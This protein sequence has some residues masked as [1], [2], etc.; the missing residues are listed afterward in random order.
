MFLG[1]EGFKGRHELK[2]LISYG[3]YLAIS[4]R[5]G[6]LLE[7]D[8]HSGDDGY[9]IRSLYL[10]DNGDSAYYDKLNGI[11]DRKKYRIRSYNF[12]SGYIT[13]ECKEKRGQYVHKTSAVLSVSEYEAIRDGDFSVL[14]SREESVCREVYAAARSKGL[15]NSVIVDYSRDPYVYPA[16]NVRITFDRELHAAGFE[17]FDIFDKGLVSV[18]VFMN[19][20]VILEVKYDDHL[21]EMIRSVI[22]SFVGTPLSVS[23]YCLCRNIKKQIHI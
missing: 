21:P 19:N 14:G 9:F 4:S 3:E 11:G 20:S 13:L 15:H 18:P 10:D 16:S 1:E 22:P 17:C 5:M 7:H 8:S 2:I 23:K 6:A 12:D